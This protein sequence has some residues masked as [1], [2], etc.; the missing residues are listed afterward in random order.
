MIEVVR[1][2][3]ALICGGPH[4]PKEC[5]EAAK[6][7]KLFFRQGRRWFR[8]TFVRNGPGRRWCIYISI[9]FAQPFPVLK[10]SL[11]RDYFRIEGTFSPKVEEIKKIMGDS[12]WTK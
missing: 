12:F 9:G 6:A 1:P 4:S 7:G 10:E 2:Y 5:E 3:K 11:N 8:A